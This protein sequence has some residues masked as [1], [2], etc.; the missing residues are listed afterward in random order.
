MC[1]ARRQGDL[2]WGLRSKMLVNYPVALWL[3]V[4]GF[5]GMISGAPLQAIGIPEEH[6][7]MALERYFRVEKP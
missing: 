6:L 4:V 1:L 5:W 7:D 2:S 3:R